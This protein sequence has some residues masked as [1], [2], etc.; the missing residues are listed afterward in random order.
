MKNTMSKMEYVLTQLWYSLLAIL[1]FRSTCFTLLYNLNKD[2]SII[3]YWFIVIITSAWGYKLTYKTKRNG[4]S[5]FVNAVLP[6]GFYAILSYANYF[7]PFYWVLIGI[8]VFLCVALGVLIF[9]VKPNSNTD[10]LKLL[11]FRFKHFLHGTRSI[12]AICLAVVIVSIGTNS[13]LGNPMYKTNIQSSTSVFDSKPWTVE[14]QIDVVEKLRP[15]I[16]G[17]LSRCE[18]QAVLGTVRNIEIK[19]LGITHPVE[20]GFS[21][22]EPNTLGEYRENL[23][24]VVIDLKHLDTSPVEDILKSL[25][26]EMYHAYQYEQIKVLEYVPKEYQQLLMFS[27]PIEYAEE[28][29]NYTDGDDNYFSYRMQ[30]LEM[31]ANNYADSGCTQYFELID[32][33][34]QGE[35]DDV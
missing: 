22:L 31:M 33:Y 16:W 15:E 34:T 32:K 17:E 20:L 23:H 14:K 18:K 2:K 3:V 10:M 9:S 12:V 13:F 30:T 4:F 35:D 19:Y 28:V 1:W 25:L 26:H 27:N 7:T 8:C 5:I 24:Q 29:V 6:N 11:K 21:V